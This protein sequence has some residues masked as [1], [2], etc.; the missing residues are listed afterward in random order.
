MTKKTKQQPKKI[1][2]TDEQMRCQ[3]ALQV[4][5]REALRHQGRGEEAEACRPAKGEVR[6]QRKNRVKPGTVG[7]S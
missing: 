7:Q 3:H 4:P 5:L 6:W 1:T 2:R